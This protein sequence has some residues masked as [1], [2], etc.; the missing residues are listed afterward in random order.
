[1]EKPTIL[2]TF[3]GVSCRA[4]VEVAVQGR[5]QGAHEIDGLFRGLVGVVGDQLFA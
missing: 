5:A 4:A 2:P 1:M 3:R